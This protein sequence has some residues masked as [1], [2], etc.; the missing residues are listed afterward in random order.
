MN[1]NVAVELSIRR[2]K[3]TMNDLDEIMSLISDAKR[4]MIDNGVYQ[5]TDDYP[6]Q[7]IVVS[8]IQNEF[9]W[10]YG[11]GVNACVTIVEHRNKCLVKRLMVRTSVSGR[12]IAKQMLKDVT[13]KT[14]ASIIEIATSH[15]NRAMLHL[16][17]KERFNSIGQYVVKDRPQFG[18]FITFQKIISDHL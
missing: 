12:G 11:S 10:L 7:Q 13:A 1:T 2:R 6:N 14:S 5:W 17:T 18:N 8:D 3:A 9:I 16:L 15:T 4:Q